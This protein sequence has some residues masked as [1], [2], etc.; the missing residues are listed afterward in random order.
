MAVQLPT[1]D[2]NPNPPQ[3]SSVGRIDYQDENAQQQ[4]NIQTEISGAENVA[5]SVGDVADEHIRNM[6]DR[7]SLNASANLHKKYDQVI[8]GDPGA[9]A[10][11]QPG[12]PGYQPARERI[13]G[14]KEDQGDPQKP[15]AD[16]NQKMAAFMQ[17]QITDLQDRGV[18]NKV[19]QAVQRAQT[20]VSQR[21]GDRIS[22]LYE[23]ADRNWNKG[24]SD[25]DAKAATQFGVDAISNPIDITNP[26]RY[27]KVDEAYDQLENSRYKVAVQFG[28]AKQVYTPDGKNIDPVDGRA[29]NYESKSPILNQQIQSDKSKM[30]FLQAKTLLASGR[31]LVTI[32]RLKSTKT[33]LKLLIVELLNKFTTKCR[34]T[35]TTN[36]LRA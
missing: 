26:K 29:F 2:I 3:V 32:T 16:A 21:W 18:S 6:A 28:T 19:I 9:P 14:A 8:N 4:R 36:Q 17:Q 34:T 20:R 33:W 12:Q 7:E 1:I 30:T 13:I 27:D 11:G 22:N 5:K 24:N 15:F 23:V 25:A 31:I 10:I 35:T